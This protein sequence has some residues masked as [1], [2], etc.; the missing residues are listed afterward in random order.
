MTPLPTLVCKECSYVNE[1]ERVY[2]HNCGAKLDRE[3]LIAQQQKQVISPEKQQRE[4]R[5]LMRPGENVLATT[6]RSLWK[7]VTLAALAAALFS[8]AMPPESMV[9]MP[10]KD[11]LTDTPQ[12]DV[13]LEKLT[14]AATGQRIAISEA[15]VNA[16]LKRERFKKVPELVNKL[17]PLQRAFVNFNKDSCRLTV[18]ANIGGY[19]L[20]LYVGLTGKLRAD[21]KTGLAATC[22]GGN[23]GRL[24]IPSFIAEQAGPAVPV[25]LGSFRHEKELLE[26]IGA[27]QVEEGQIILGSRGRTP[28]SPPPSLLVSPSRPAAH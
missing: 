10:N 22:T 5:K 7:T 2:C 20:P 6:W 8:A 1:G 19:D 26:K 21:P 4:I 9:P 24:P 23:I 28:P 25:L 11:E 12:L 13:A 15:Q 27:V 16:Y 18:Q 3:G 17:I 14:G